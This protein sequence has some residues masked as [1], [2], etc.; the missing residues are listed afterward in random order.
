MKNRFL[1]AAVTAA[2]LFFLTAVA[3][4]AATS[5]PAPTPT[6][7]NSVVKAVSQRMDAVA[8]YQAHVRV[9]LR[10]HSFPFLA[11]DLDG[12]TTYQ[13]PGH[14]TVTF[15]SVPAL[16]SAFQK[17]SGDIGDPAAWPQKY[18]IAIDTQTPADP[19]E[20]VL[21]LTEKVRGQIDHALAYVDT[22]NNTVKRMDWFYY[23][24]GHIAMNQHFAPESGVLLVDHQT[25][26]INMP[27]YRASADAV[28]DGY[29][30]KVSMA[31][32]R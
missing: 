27:G 20:V 5:T 11:A 21:R 23:S 16:A 17:V 30:V 1:N 29:N 8:A 32:R 3:A 4:Q 13:R 12:T 15:N 22:T 7:A 6:D 14:Y 10:M 28:F 19:N 31:S 26:D 2:A 9:A 25:A 18:A 24:G